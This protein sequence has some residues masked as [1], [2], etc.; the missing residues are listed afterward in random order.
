MI[1]S[2]SPAHALLITCE[3]YLTELKLRNEPHSKL[4]K[5]SHDRSLLAVIYNER[6]KQVSGVKMQQNCRLKLF[7]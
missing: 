7:Y 5:T 6:K 2:P 3:D 4:N 1:L